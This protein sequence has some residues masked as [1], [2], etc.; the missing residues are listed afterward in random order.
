MGAVV[1]QGR[2]DEDVVGDIEHDIGIRVARAKVEAT[3]VAVAGRG[4]HEPV[5]QTVRPDDPALFREGTIEVT[6]RAEEAV[7]AKEARV[8]EEVVVGKQVQERVETIRDTVRR[9]DV[10]VQPIDRAGDDF[11][12]YANDFQQHFRNSFSTGNAVYD[13]YLPAYR[14][15][16]QLGGDAQYRGRS[17]DELSSGFRRTWEPMHPNTW[18]RF[19]DAIRYGWER[20]TGTLRA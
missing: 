16:W 6:E 4:Q 13:E 5:D 19:Q 2:A 9:T 7:V 15:G 3:R 20:R 11:D 17:W 14:Y 18:D 10:D 8:I 1:Y 12:Q